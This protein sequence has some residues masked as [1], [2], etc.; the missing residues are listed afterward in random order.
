MMSERLLNTCYVEENGVRI[1]PNCYKTSWLWKCNSACGYLEN[2]K[3][4]VTLES[5][6]ESLIKITCV[7][8]FKKCGD[9]VTQLLFLWRRSQSLITFSVHSYLYTVCI[10]VCKTKRVSNPNLSLRVSTNGCSDILRCPII[11]RLFTGQKLSL[12]RTGGATLFVSLSLSL[13][14]RTNSWEG[15]CKYSMQLTLSGMCL[16]YAF[17]NHLSG[18]EEAKAWRRYPDIFAVITVLGNRWML[19][20][21]QAG[22]QHVVCLWRSCNYATVD[23]QRAL[24]DSLCFCACGFTRRPITVGIQSVCHVVWVHWNVLAVTRERGGVPERLAG[25]IQIISHSMSGIYCV[26]TRLGLFITICP[27]VLFRE[28]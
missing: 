18:D 15:F 16:A 24:T 27:F 9:H 25:L 13:L 26:T 19:S 2:G 4:E 22:G 6:L 8:R 23:Y 12:S 11:P 3:C 10:L 5:R 7:W 28:F 17:P 14:F 1:N 20:S 21:T